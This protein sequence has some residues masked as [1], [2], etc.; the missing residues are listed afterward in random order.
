MSAADRAGSATVPPW[1]GSPG[2]VWRMAADSCFDSGKMLVADTGMP[3]DV[4]SRDLGV[5]GPDPENDLEVLVA[6][7]LGEFDLEGTPV[8]LEVSLSGLGDSLE[9]SALD[10]AVGNQAFDLEPDLVAFVLVLAP[11]AS[12]Q[13]SGLASVVW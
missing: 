2:L 6:L 10:L 5:A 1:E 8:E 12:A 4:V 9:D 7:G 3:D 11:V 13:G